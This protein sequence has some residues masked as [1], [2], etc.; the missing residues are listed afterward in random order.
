MFRYNVKLNLSSID[1][2]DDK[3]PIPLWYCKIDI[4]SL[5]ILVANTITN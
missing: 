5:L 2:A 3:L 1:A 4:P